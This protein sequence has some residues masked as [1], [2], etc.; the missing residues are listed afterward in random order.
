[1]ELNQAAIE[2]AIV[3]SA[4]ERLLENRDY[5]RQIDVEFKSRIDTLFKEQAEVRIRAAIDQ[6]VEDGFDREYRRVDSWG[7]PQGE[8]TTIRKQLE[9]A[10]S[11]YWE[12]KVDSNGKETKDSYSSAMTRAQYVMLKACGEDFSKLLKA[13]AVT[14]T[15]HL[16]DGLRAQLRDFVDKALKDLFH[17]RSQQD[18]AE[19]RHYG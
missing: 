16:K 17:V 2:K 5:T 18:Q 14:V 7:Q 12:K 19:G 10:V 6:A 15:A 8:A 13:E 3:E 1:M 11:G 4:V 9:D